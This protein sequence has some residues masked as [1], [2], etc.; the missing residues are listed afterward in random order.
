MGLPKKNT[1]ERIQDLTLLEQNI[2]EPILTLVSALLQARQETS[3]MGEDKFQGLDTAAF[4]SVWAPWGSQQCQLE[5]PWQE[6]TNF[7]CKV[8][9]CHSL[10]KP[11]YT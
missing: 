11:L 5:V 8:Q 3:G 9:L 7:I 2:P 10:N 6:K 4:P 1:Q